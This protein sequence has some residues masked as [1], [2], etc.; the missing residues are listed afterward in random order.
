MYVMMIRRMGYLTLGLMIALFL[1]RATIIELDFFYVVPTPQIIFKVLMASYYDWLFATTIGVGCMVMARLLYNKPKALHILFRS[2]LICVFLSVLFA[3]INTQVLY[4]LGVPLNYGW[5]Y[6]S[7]FLGNG[8][9]KEAIMANLSWKILVSFP[10]IIMALWGIEYLMRCKST[11]LIHNNEYSRLGIFSVSFLLIFY[12]ITARCYIAYNPLNYELVANP[13]VAFVESLCSFEEPKLF[14]LKLPENFEPFPSPHRAFADIKYKIPKT[15]IRNVVLFVLE[16]VPAE[17]V[18]GY[19]SKYD[20][21]PN[22]ERS[23]K[24]AVLFSDIY[25]HAPV[26]HNSLVSLLG[27]IYPMISYKSISNE[28]PQIDW[29]TLSSELK[30]NNYRTAFFNASDNRFQKIDEF[31]SYR[32]F[33][34]ITDQRDM[35][36][37][38]FFLPGIGMEEDYMIEAFVKW[39]PE[40]NTKQSFFAMLWTKETHYPYKLSIREKDYGVKNPE[41]NRYLNAL[42]HSDSMLGKLLDELK[43]RGLAE[44]TL[45]VIVADHGEAFGRHNQRGHGA[46]IYEENVRVPLIF[47]NPGLFN[48]QKLSVVGGHVDVAPTIMNTLGLPC[49]KEW[50]GMSFFDSSRIERAYFLSPYSCHSF[51]YRTPEHKIIFNATLNKT[52]IFDL[53]NDPEETTNLAEQMP[54]LVKISAQRLAQWIQFHSKVV[55]ERLSQPGVENEAKAQIK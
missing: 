45:I 24:H 27:S 49:P 33:D 36:C 16:S 14:T 34:K 51:G 52:M 43:H 20:V 3:I 7:D 40:D 2:F 1:I 25:A 15:K 8:I 38:E 29:P 32:R 55:K 41:L 17:Y 35:F 31:L 39:L 46:N 6:Y 42:H 30:N 12:F 50:Q 18:S 53:H 28:Y 26:T 22:I 10:L 44:S 54:E 19:N 13:V 4:R 11:K 48:G 21:T 47:I 9:N 5:L 37:K 23:L